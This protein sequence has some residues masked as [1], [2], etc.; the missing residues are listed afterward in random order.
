MGLF[1]KCIFSA[2]EGKVMLNGE[3]V[4]GARVKRYYEWGNIEKENTFLTKTNDE[5]RFSF[6]EINISSLSASLNIISQPTII[7]NI[8]IEHEGREYTAWSFFKGNYESG[9][10]T[11]TSP[12]EL[13]CDLSSEF[14]KHKLMSKRGEYHGIC[15]LKNKAIS[16]WSD[17][18]TDLKTLPTNYN[19][20]MVHRGFV[21]TFR[22]FEHHI[23]RYL[24]WYSPS[25]IHLVCYRLG[26]FTTRNQESISGGTVG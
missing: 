23:D 9:G 3:P 24:D 19:C 22:S 20:H 16:S 10:E 6:S 13:Y 5:G 11:G 21:Q 2:V 18:K 12:I 1:S 25:K 26:D 4:S 7:Q 17:T 8:T 14:T 15:T